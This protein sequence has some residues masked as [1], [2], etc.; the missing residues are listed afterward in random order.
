MDPYPES[1]LSIAVQRV[2]EKGGKNFQFSSSTYN[3]LYSV[4]VVA[5]AGNIGQ[6]SIMAMGEPAIVS[7]A[8]AVGSVDNTYTLALYTIIA[9]DG[10]KIFYR[11]GI[12][13]GGWKSNVSA[14]ITI[15][16]RVK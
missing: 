4:Y 16:S 9:P 12:G 5:A 3:T 2:I 1:L 14:T 15:D 6:A 8:M 13:F 10:R 7:S 11:A